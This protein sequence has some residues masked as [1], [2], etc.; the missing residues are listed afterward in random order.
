MVRSDE[1]GSGLAL[2]PAQ[3]PESQLRSLW[4]ALDDD[5]SGYITAKEFGQFMNKG[6]P[7][8]AK[9]SRGSV[10][11]KA[12]EKRRLLA[13]RNRTSLEQEKAE[14]VEIELRAAARQ[15]KVHEAE[16]ALLQAELQK[17]TSRASPASL[18]SPA[19]SFEQ[20]RPAQTLPHSSELASEL[21]EP[22][23]G[24]S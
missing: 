24:E 12:V 8:A 10:L 6:V 22:P 15:Q 14:R 17:L 3:L 20:S 2:R 21:D 9:T 4:R 23:A 11:E 1:I 5:G 16:K 19:G 18:P 13:V 7:E